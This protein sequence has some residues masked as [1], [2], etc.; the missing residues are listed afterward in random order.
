[1]TKHPTQRS[2]RFSKL[3]SDYGAEF[4]RDALTRFIVRFNNPTFTSRQVETESSSI[5][6]PFN[7][8]P[9]F[10]RIKYT[11]EDPYTT[12]GPSDSVIDSIHVQPA[13]L[14]AN[15][16]GF[17]GRFDTALVNDGSGK[18]IGTDGYRVAQVRA[19]FS[20]KPQHIKTLFPSDASPPTY[21]A[22]IEWFSPF[23]SQPEP[24]HLMYK[25]KRSLKEGSRMVSVIPVANI[26]RS[27]HLI[28]KFGP[29]APPEWTREDILR[30]LPLFSAGTRLCLED[31]FD[32]HLTSVHT[33]VS[34][35]SLHSYEPEVTDTLLGTLTAPCLKRLS[36][37]GWFSITGVTSFFDRS[38]CP[39]THLSIAW[40][41]QFSDEMLA[42]LGSP[43]A[44]DIVDF[45]VTL[46]GALM[47]RKL[48]D[49]LSKHDIVPNLRALAFR[50]GVRLDEAKVLEIH[51]N[52]RPTL[53]SLWLDRPGLLSQDTVQ[54]LKSG[55]LEVM[56]FSDK[57]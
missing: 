28:P 44:R 19:V 31:Y 1:M 26:R 37:T 40:Y 22:Y 8:V 20:F 41:D 18:M 30:I 10:H 32:A 5:A 16:K 47:P 38:L 53:Q 36:V 48:A 4:F 14:A 2:V 21:L 39:L 49:A 3:V 45:D 24:H 42:L 11:T 55:G 12:G 17:P 13:K 35:L 50:R 52:R 46:P 57:D 33:I 6:L 9:V 27:V 15:G 7:S 29:V 34:D 56:L 54:A 43:H 25:I 51:A 23:P